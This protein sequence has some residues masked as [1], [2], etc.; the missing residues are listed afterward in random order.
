MRKKQK[1]T[2]GVSK[3]KTN[4]VSKKAKAVPPLPPLPPLPPPAPEKPSYR[5]MKREME[6]EIRAFRDYLVAKYTNFHGVDMRKDVSWYMEQM[7]VGIH[8]EIER[9]KRE[10]RQRAIA[11]RLAAEKAAEEAAAATEQK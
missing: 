8:S 3:K 11:E 2:N 6:D 10:E 9:E 1:Q 4:G 5:D 7:G